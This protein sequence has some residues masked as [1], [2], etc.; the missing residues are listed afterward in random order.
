MSELIDRSLVRASELLSEGVINEAE[1]ICRQVL[2]VDGEN[3]DAMCLLS[4]C[5]IRSGK[6][7]DSESLIGKIKE[8]FEGAGLHNS[9]GISYMHAKDME[10]AITHFSK[11]AELN[12]NDE[13]SRFNAASCFMM[14][15]NFKRSIAYFREAYAVS[16]SSRS[17]IG[18][19]CSKAEM[20]DFEGAIELLR[21]VL[22][23]D[24]EN[25]Q[26]RTDMASILHLA[27]RWEEAWSYYPSRLVHY[28]RLRRTVESMGLP[29]WTEGEPPEG[30]ILVFS[31]Q[32]VGDAINFARMSLNLQK[33]YPDRE[34]GVLVTPQLRGLLQSQGLRTVAGVDG[35]DA[36]CSMMDL[37]GLLGM[38]TGE[39]SESFVPMRAGKCDM[40]AFDGMLKVGVCWAG[41]PA[42]PKDHQRSFGL[43]RFKDICSMRGIKLFSLQK[44]TRPRVWP[45]SDRPVDLSCGT[46]GMRLV[47]MSKYMN[48]WEDTAA[49][50]SSLDL[51]ISADTSVLHLSASL[52][53]ETWGL[54]P[55]VPDWR[56]GMSSRESCWYPSLKLFRQASRGDWEGVFSAVRDELG[57]KLG[58]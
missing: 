44:D 37:P 34:V 27:G 49:I 41:N 20:L 14:L 57:R 35:F 13:D 19:A 1:L 40:S 50:I 30:K 42:H 5:L 46:E 6:R 31:E 28:E 48:S 32:G 25:H 38:T 9:L 2:K 15:G 43:E 4:C 3:R 12:P 51:V 26:A 45:C 21:M 11:A 7:D 53:K 47:D 10:A 17:M 54:L 33:K 8:S 24:P 16:K 52:G 56:W 55:C 58:P 23:S 18:M 29:V 22:K 36:C 39:V